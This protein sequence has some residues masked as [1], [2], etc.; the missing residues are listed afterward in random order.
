MA[1]ITEEMLDRA[2][3]MLRQMLREYEGDIDR[4]YC[5][6][7]DA[8]SISLSLKFKPVGDKID[9]EAGFSF[10]AEKIADKTSEIFDPNQLGLF[11][12]EKN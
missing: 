11:N 2:T 7:D 4:A 9:I 6:T 1:K 10:T 8:L 12:D 3:A 5:A